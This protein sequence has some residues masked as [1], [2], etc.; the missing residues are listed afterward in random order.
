MV[1]AVQL[2]FSYQN[3]GIAEIGVGSGQHH[4]RGEVLGA[5]DQS[6]FDY[7]AVDDAAHRESGSRGGAKA[8]S[9]RSDGD[10]SRPGI[11][12]VGAA[13]CPVEV[14]DTVEGQGFAGDRDAAFEFE[15]R[16]G[17]AAGGG[18]IDHGAR[19]GGSKGVWVQDLDRAGADGG[20][21]AVGIPDVKGEG[22]DAGV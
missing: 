3:I 14:A 1:A 9:C 22:T 19:R 18:A 15:P 21:A 5:D 12:A 2:Q 17:R 11:A 6:G 20:Q 7:A 8:C 16:V 4:G 13:Q 10:I